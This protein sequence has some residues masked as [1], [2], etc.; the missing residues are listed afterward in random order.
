[1]AHGFTG[2]KEDAADQVGRLAAGGFH[3]VAPDLR[4]HGGSHAPPSGY[5][6]DDFA[7]DL[8]G[9][10]DALGWATFALV[11]HSLGG[12]VAQQVALRDPDRLDALVLVGTTHGAVGLDPGVVALACEVVTTGGMAALLDAQ[13]ALGGGPLQTS[14]ALRLLER[15]PGWAAYKDAR[16]LASSPA[17]YVECA[18]AMLTLPSRLDALRTLRVPTLVVVGELDDVF[19]A[20]SR[21]LA[22]AIPG[23][24][25]V[26]VREAG[27]S[28]HV[29]EPDAWFDAVA[30]WLRRAVG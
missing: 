18:T 2:A 30:P 22:A 11:G 24:S 21:E 8:V 17:M 28:P 26:V 25:L 16:L 27:H 1:M 15:R 4:G 20:G 13:R 5:S 19:L 10:A 14:A 12:M 23:A 3:V 7:D 29:E 6:L 9:L